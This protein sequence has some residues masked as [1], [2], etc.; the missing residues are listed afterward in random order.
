MKPSV[1]LLAASLLAT[2][3]CNDDITGLEP[4]SDPATETFAASLGIDLAAMTRTPEGLYLVDQVVGTGEAIAANTD[5]VRVT[6]ALFLKDGGLVESNTANFTP[7]GVIPGFRIGL[8]G[9]KPGGRR[10]LVIPSELGYGRVTQYTLVD[11]EK[12]VKIPRQSTLIFDLEVRNVWN[13]APT[14]TPPT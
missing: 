14:P 12:R 6:Y 11:G 10:R 5:S 3:S 4:P 1:L 8:Q 2:A 7:S 13:P 9:M